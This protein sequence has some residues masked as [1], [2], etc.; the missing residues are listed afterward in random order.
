MKV[1]K[2]ITGLFGLFLLTLPSCD[3]LDIVPD[4][5]ATVDMAFST[6]QNA[7][8]FLLTCY[9]Y[10]PLH[11]NVLKNPAL[12]TGDEVWNCAEK[13]FYYTNSTS[14]SIAKGYQ[15]VSDPYLNY[16]SG[17]RDGSNLFIA[18]R[19][20]NTFLENIHK[21]PDMGEGEKKLWIAEVKVLKAFF[22]Y[23]LMQLYGPIPVQR[24]NISVAASP[25][26]VKVEREPVDKV[27]E[28]MV[29]LIDEAT[30]SDGEIEPALPLFIRAQTT[31]MGR[32]TLP[33]ALAIKAKILTLAA[34]P[35]FNGN[36]DFKEYKNKDGI[37][38]INPVA[39][40][41]KW[42]KAKDACKEAIDVAHQAGHELYVFNDM[43]MAQISDTTFLE[44]TLRNT[45]TS[46]FNKEL[47][48][49][50]G[51]NDVTTLQGI[52]NPPLTSYH[53]GSQISW[54]KSMHNPTMNVVEQFYTQNG[55]PIDEDKTYDYDN[56]YKVDVAPEGHDFYIEKD[57]R[58]AYLHFYR[59][60]RFY[61]YIGFDGGKWFNLEAP[62]DK[63]AL[64]VHNKAGEVAGRSLDNY[65]ITG[66][67]T[68][69]I[70]NYKLIMTASTNTGSTIS[71]P[72]PIIRL[73]DLYLLYAEAL[74]ECQ[75]TPDAEVY[76]YIQLVRDKA[77]LDKETG[78]L[79][80]TWASYS[81]NQDKPKT[82]EG[83]REIIR[84]ERL[85]ELAFE[86]HRF[87]DLRRWRWSRDYLNQPIRGWNVTEKNEIGYYQ[88][89]YLFFRKF[90]P[91]DY[92]WPIKQQDLYVNDKLVQS[93]Q[94]D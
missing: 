27:V 24:E 43:L 62:N 64:V 88:V 52:A 91:R 48:W 61:A 82:Q 68:K 7:E 1:K 2:Y 41:E 76:K 19:D 14:F 16:W 38:Y 25:E 75:A 8:R 10:V 85:I 69:K 77:G 11:G 31:D 72:F 29:G 18:M 51:N 74:N 23:Y 9:S 37:P 79:V 44:L 83:M 67:F 86:G 94:W 42:V 3:F 50:L 40:P 22:H 4:D 60:P 36:P 54:T 20:C 47:I 49:G 21:V 90:L 46:R 63:S 39:D 78:N 70:I 33:A 81:K 5:I 87:Y 57:F 93:P 58:T 53:Q 66:Y 13:T 59:E 65:S 28:Y 30:S 17:G 89:T 92:F 32:L 12:S 45:I 71:Y 35:L 84:R 26:K 15:N 56:R 73:A 34:S 55:V 6:R 80:D